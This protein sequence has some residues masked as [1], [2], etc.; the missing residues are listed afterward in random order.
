MRF[1]TY[2]RQLLRIHLAKR[3]AMHLMINIKNKFALS[4]ILARFLQ[5]P[6]LFVWKQNGAR[7]LFGRH[8]S[9]L[10]VSPT[11]RM[12]SLIAALNISA[13]RAQLPV[14]LSADLS[15]S[16][17]TCEVAFGQN[18]FVSALGVWPALRISEVKYGKTQSIIIFRSWLF[19]YHHE[20]RPAGVMSFSDLSFFC[21]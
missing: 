15:E 5:I 2:L 13:A 21:P 6:V 3:V 1:V 12:L 17:L 8:L 7:A 16:Q 9:P 10:P 20:W 14:F 18:G 4:Q 11:A 19:A